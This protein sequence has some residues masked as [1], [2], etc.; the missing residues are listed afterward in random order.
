MLSTRSRQTLLHGEE[1]MLEAAVSV[2]TAGL[3]PWVTQ[4]PTDDME[5]AV[6]AVPPNSVTQPVSGAMSTA[7][8][9]P[10]VR[11]SAVRNCLCRRRQSPCTGR[12]ASGTE[13][14]SIF[15]SFDINSFKFKCK[16]VTPYHTV[17]L[18]RLVTDSILP[19]APEPQ[20]ARDDGV[21]KLRATPEGDLFP[22]LARG[23]NIM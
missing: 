2:T 10:P 20:H 12:V 15:I 3:Y 5:T 8:R 6:M 19:A 9:A 11:T 17:Q 22:W 23:R 14:L 7:E 18:Q 13:E 4:A 21:L 1:D 16:F